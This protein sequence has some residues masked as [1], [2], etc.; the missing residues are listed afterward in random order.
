MAHS[1]SFQVLSL[2]FINPLIYKTF[3]S[4]FDLLL[5]NHRVVKI[6]LYK[7]F[8]NSILTIFHF[9]TSLSDTETEGPITVA[10][11]YQGLHEVSLF[12]LHK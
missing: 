4:I 12:C 2:I 6:F 11:W 9:V 5:P 8:Q 3:D 1:L 7:I 10:T